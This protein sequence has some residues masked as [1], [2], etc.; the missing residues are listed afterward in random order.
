MKAIFSTSLLI[1]ILAR[2][3]KNVNTRAKN[4]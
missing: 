4:V 2:K 3:N 1:A